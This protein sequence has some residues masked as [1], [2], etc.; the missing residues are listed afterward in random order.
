MAPAEYTPEAVDEAPEP[1]I[2]PPVARMKT[3]G[4]ESSIG[5]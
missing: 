2:V 4:K 3:D 5:D 1:A